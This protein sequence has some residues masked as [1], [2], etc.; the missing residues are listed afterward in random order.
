MGIK[1][2]LKQ[3]IGRRPPGTGWQPIAGGKKGGYRKMVGGRWSYW[4]P[5]MGEGGGSQKQAEAHQAKKDIA[6][7]EKQAAKWQK[8]YSKRLDQGQ[9]RSHVQSAM[10]QRDHHIKQAKQLRDKHGIKKSQAALDLER[11][12]K[13]QEDTM[14]KSEKG[15]GAGAAQGPRDG[16]GTGPRDGRGGACPGRANKSEEEEE[17]EAKKGQVS[18][19]PLPVGKGGEGNDTAKSVMVGKCQVHLSPDEALSKAI[20][21]GEFGIGTVARTHS[22]KTMNRLK[23]GVVGGEGFT[24]HGAD[25]RETVARAEQDA[26][27]LRMDPAGNCGNGGLPDWFA[28]A[29]KTQEPMV[30]TP[31]V[32]NKA[33]QPATRVIDD[34]DPYTKRLHQADPRDTAAADINFA[35]NRD[36][37][38]TR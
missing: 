22:S 3:A 10:D 8:K 26:E 35:Y 38:R 18:P 19:V 5:G 15:M 23:K 27:I 16:R 31:A 30:R 32:M 29:Q 37:K 24:E 21:D 12:I 11:L 9:H 7:H 4:Y 33:Q 1:E 20:E 14:R 34:D 25:Q 17:E 13:S 36:A 2:R 6:H 28:D